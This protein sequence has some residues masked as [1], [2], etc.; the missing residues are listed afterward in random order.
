M[1]ESISDEKIEEI[2]YKTFVINILSLTI[3][4]FAARP[5]LKVIFDFSDGDY[6]DFLEKRKTDLPEFFLNAIRKR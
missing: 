4:P 5:L 6:D 1:R 2:G 3:F